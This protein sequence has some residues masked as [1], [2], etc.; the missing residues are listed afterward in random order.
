MANGKKTKA[1]GKCKYSY[2]T[3]NNRSKPD[4]Y[5]PDAELVDLSKVQLKDFFTEE[6]W[7]NC[8][9]N[10]NEK[11]EPDDQAAHSELVEET[12]MDEPCRPSHDMVQLLITETGIHPLLAEKILVQHSCDY[13]SARDEAITIPIDRQKFILTEQFSNETGID[14][15]L[16]FQLLEHNQWYFDSAKDHLVSILIQQ[17][18]S[19]TGIEE[20]SARQLILLHQF[21]YESSKQEAA[22]IMS[23]RNALYRSI[24]GNNTT[25]YDEMT[26]T[27]GLFGYFLVVAS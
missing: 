8:P 20:S 5:H 24:Q 19:D 21:N 17:L 27:N 22:F 14:Q 3:T 9:W 1:Q 10:T 18:V 16:A 13:Y 15:S 6:E 23:R 11:K 7:E 2:N 12:P 25:R 26:Y 4:W